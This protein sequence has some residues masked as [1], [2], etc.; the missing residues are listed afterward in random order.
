MRALLRCTTFAAVMLV[1]TVS[2]ADPIA[3]GDLIKF[4]GSTGGLGGGAFLV[5][6]TS[7]GA[8]DDFMT[9]CLQM[10]QHV[11]YSSLF[12][13]GGITNF[14]DDAA[15]NDP[16]STATAWIFSSF[17]AG[18]LTGYTP[19]EIQGA[20]WTLEDEWTSSA[21][22]SAALITLAENRV[23]AGWVNDGVGVLNL[24]YTDGRMAQDQLTYTRVANLPP[25]PPEP[26][27]EPAT[28]VLVGLGGLVL[29][30]RKRLRRRR[31]ATTA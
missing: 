20:I 29:G 31:P 7:N 17:R 18:L 2:S 26:T 28:L 11:D 9:F 22:N 12:R 25:P 23:A 19:D 16:L 13:V 21:G 6:N 3:I 14:A 24:F 8:G 10:T 30:S 4:Q 5:D 27:P 15:G 1:A